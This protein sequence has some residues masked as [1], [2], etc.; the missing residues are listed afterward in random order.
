VRTLRA[1]GLV[2]LALILCAAIAGASYQFIEAYADALRF[3]PQGRLVDIGGYKLN[4][5]CSGRGSPAVMLEAGLEEPAISWAKVQSGIAQFTRVCS[6]DRAGYAWSDPATRPRTER[7][8]TAEL[9]R[10]LQ[11]AGEKPPYVLVGHSMGAGIVRFYNGIY[12]NDVVGVVLVDGGPNPGDLKMPDSIQKMSIADLK[13]RQRARMF[14]HPL[15]FFGISRFLARKDISDPRSSYED[16]EWS[17]FHIQP[18]VVDAVTGEVEQNFEPRTI[19]ELRAL[20]NLGDKP[21]I[22]LIAGK[23]VFGVTPLPSDDWIKL[24]TSWI[25]GSKQLPELLSSSGKW[26]LVP[27]S[28][29][30]IPVERPDA[31]VNAAREVYNQVSSR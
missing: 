7:E 5:I 11:S 24:Q 4:L 16:R 22:V 18:K 6:Y 31:I 2:L 17:Y 1:A 15:Y 30:M 10:L 23:G 12:P 19:Q 14:A 27:D 9:H 20:P 29:H 28:T 26:V 25:N 8:I 21:L 13:R 3:P